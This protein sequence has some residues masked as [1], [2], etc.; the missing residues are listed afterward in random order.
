MA[1]MLGAPRLEALGRAIEEE[2]PSLEAA[3]T[4]VEELRQAVTDTLAM[5]EQ[6]YGPLS[7]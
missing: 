4:L 7:L 2:A 3:I 6:R 1:G 5:L